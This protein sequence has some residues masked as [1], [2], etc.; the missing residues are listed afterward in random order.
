MAR[1]WLLAGLFVLALAALVAL[2]RAVLRTLRTARLCSVPLRV[3]QDIEFPAAGRALLCMEGPRFTPRFRKLRFD[4]RLPGGPALAGQRILFRTVTSGIAKARVSLR[5]FDL[6]YSGRYQLDIHGLAPADI[7]TPQHSVVFMR[8]H[9]ARSLLLIVGIVCASGLAIASLVFLLMLA[10]PTAAAIDPGRADGYVRLDGTRVELHE[11][12]A[13]L[14]PNRD[15]HLPF[16][17]ELRIVLADREVPQASLAGLDPLPVLELARSGQV[18]GLLLRLDPDDPGTLTVTLLFPTG[19]RDG[20]LVTRRYSSAGNGLIRALRLA[21]QRVGG[22]L[23]CP[24]APDL[25]CE[26]HFSAPV[27]NE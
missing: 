8:P 11:A 21:P 7:D 18:R 6:P 20:T 1:P 15:G 17:P 12:F 5:S 2:I 26:A 19:A 3:H 13:H 4:L 10:I 27:F 24:G 9:F 16:T 25:E 14:H 22:D 23:A